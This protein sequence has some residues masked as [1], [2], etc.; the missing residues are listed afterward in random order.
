[1][2]RLLD[3]RPII[4]E[5]WDET[6]EFALHRPGMKLIADSFHNQQRVVLFNCNKQA[7][8]NT[9]NLFSLGNK[10]LIV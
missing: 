7:I 5:I 10:G 3:H 2:L 4:R 8:T 9:F 1:M 6:L